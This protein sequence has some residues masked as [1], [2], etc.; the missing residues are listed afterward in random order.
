ML[1]VCWGE[2][3]GSPH[4][5]PIP[6]MRHQALSG[7]QSWPSSPPP[8]LGRDPPFGGS[9]L[10]KLHHH[11]E[12]VTTETAPNHDLMLGA[13]SLT[14]QGCAV[15]PTARLRVWVFFF[16]NKG[17]RSKNCQAEGPSPPPPRGGSTHP[18]LRL[19]W[20]GTT[21]VAW[22]AWCSK[23][24]PFQLT[25]WPPLTNGDAPPLSPPPTPS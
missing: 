5:Q 8:Q 18:I 13:C 16:F 25:T 24:L 21:W 10:R 6:F 17:G 15:S 2:A 12:E 11:K 19:P 9:A 14:R 7:A 20:P 4:A 1:L 23:A 22:T 3:S